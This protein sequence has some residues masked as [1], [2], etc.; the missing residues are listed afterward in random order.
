[1]DSTK[2]NGKPTNKE[3]KN[4]ILAIQAKLKISTLRDELKE[5]WERMMVSGGAPD[6][7][8]LGEKP[9]QICRQYISIIYES[10]NWNEKYGNRLKK[11]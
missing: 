8:S 3:D 1:M 9:E 6:I 2:I 5:R 7:E 4:H 11:N 10:L